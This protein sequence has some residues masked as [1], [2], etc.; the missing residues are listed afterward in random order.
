[1][2]IAGRY[3]GPQAQARLA[4]VQLVADEL[5]VLPSQVVLA[6]LAQH[7]PRVVPIIGTATPARLDQAVAALDVGLSADQLAHLAAA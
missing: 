5:G 7:S 3:S 6:W 1:M 2:E 4:S